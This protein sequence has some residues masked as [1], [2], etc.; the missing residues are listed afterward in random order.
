MQTAQVAAELDRHRERLLSDA[1]QLTG[2]V[3]L[4]RMRSWLPVVTDALYTLTDWYDAPYVFLVQP[5]STC[6]G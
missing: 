4:K 1:E 2:G 6:S 5:I 3:P